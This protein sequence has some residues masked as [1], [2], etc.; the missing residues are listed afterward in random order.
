MVGIL[1]EMEPHHVLSMVE[2]HLDQM[3]KKILIQ[4]GL[5]EITC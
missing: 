4:E 3:V 2:K 1:D 5:R